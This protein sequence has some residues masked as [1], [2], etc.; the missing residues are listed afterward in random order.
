MEGNTIAEMRQILDALEQGKQIEWYDSIYNTWR[1]LEVNHEKP[2][3]NFIH[4]IKT[5][6]EETLLTNRELSKW[7]A[8]GKGEFTKESWGSANVTLSYSKAH[9]DESVDCSL[10]IRKWSDTEWHKPTREYAFGEEDE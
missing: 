8:Q 1:D 3:F 4:R 10:L 2:N 6:T 7:L 9:G 5:E